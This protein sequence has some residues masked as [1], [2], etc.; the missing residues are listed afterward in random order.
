MGAVAWAGAGFGEGGSLPL[1]QALK[2]LT[3]EHLILT[4]HPGAGM[5][6]PFQEEDLGGA[7]Q[8]LPHQVCDLRPVMS[9]P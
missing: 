3:A 2:G 4:A 8:P 5:P 9:F 6:G 7:S 1:R